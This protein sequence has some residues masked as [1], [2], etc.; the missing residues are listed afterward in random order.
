MAIG[1]GSITP[2]LT[3]ISTSARRGSVAIVAP[4]AATPSLASL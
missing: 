4:K 3:S 1:S 2:L